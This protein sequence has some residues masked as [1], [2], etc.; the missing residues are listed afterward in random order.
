[1]I[2]PN[3]A[4]AFVPLVW[5]FMFLLEPN[6]PLWRTWAW[7]SCWSS[8]PPFSCWSSSESRLPLSFLLASLIT[9][10]ASHHWSFGR[11][12][13]LSRLAFLLPLAPPLRSYRWEWKGS[14][15]SVFWRWSG[16]PTTPLGVLSPSFLYYLS[17]SSSASQARIC[18]LPWPIRWPAND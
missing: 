16:M 1:M 10:P 4:L 8:A 5:S 2:I 3:V 7:P 9:F 17:A 18:W 6:H 11:S 12:T 13:G 15:S 14:L